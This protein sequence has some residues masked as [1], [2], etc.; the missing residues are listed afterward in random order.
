[1]H[2][3]SAEILKTLM[4]VPIVSGSQHHIPAHILFSALL[5]NVVSA[6]QKVRNLLLIF[7]NLKF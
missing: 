1:M 5:L 2:I 3:A 6:L 4:L 7:N